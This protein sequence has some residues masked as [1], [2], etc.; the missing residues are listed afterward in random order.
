MKMGILGILA[1]AAAAFSQENYAQWS[2]YRDITINTSASGANVSG[3]VTNFPV[4]VRLTSGN[5]TDFATAGTKASLR[6]ARGSTPLKY[7]VDSFDSSGSLGAQ[8]WVSVDSVFG[9]NAA[10]SI[11]MYW[12]KSAAPDSSSGPKVFAPANKFAAVYHMGSIL[13]E[14]NNVTLSSSALNLKAPP[15]NPTDLAPAFVTGNIGQGLSFNGNGTIG[16]SSAM[17]VNS[18]KNDAAF[19]YVT[20]RTAHYTLS[21]WVKKGSSQAAALGMVI[22]KNYQYYLGF[23]NITN[24]WQMAEYTNTTGTD[25]VAVPAVATSDGWNYVV[26]VRNGASMTLYVNGGGG[27][28]TTF[29]GT[30]PGLNR[31]GGGTFNQTVGIGRDGGGS[32]AD[33]GVNPTSGSYFNGSIDELRVDSTSRSS[34]WVNL[35]YQTQNSAQTAVTV[36][37]AQNNVGPTITSL[38]PSDTT[39]GLGATATFNVAAT[40]TTPLIYQWMK[41]GVA[42]NTTANPS[43]ATASLVLASVAVGDTA[44]YTCVVS[45]SVNTSGVTS[46]A[47]NLHLNLAPTITTQ[48][49]DSTVVSGAGV[50]FTVAASGSGTLSYQWKKNGTNV[51]NGG[52]LSGATS[53]V[54]SVSA[55]AL[56][57]TGAYTVVVT[58]TLNGPTVSSTSGA[59]KLI[60]NAVS[61]ATQ[62]RD[63]TVLS[64]VAAGFTVAAS[65]TGVLSYQWKKNGANVS[66]GGTLSGATS[67]ALGVSSVAIT[68][69]G[70]Y[71]V[72]VT[73]TLNGTIATA[74]SNAGRLFVGIAPSI[75]TQPHDSTVVSGAAAGFTVAASGSGTLS[76]QW[77][78]NGTNV[79]NGGT[80]SG[81]TS[82]VLNV[83]AA[84]IT[85]TGAYTVAVTSTL[86]GTTTVATSS[87]G[88]LFV[89]IIPSITTQPHDST[90][91][92]G[93]AAGFT[94]AASGSGTL[95]YQWKKNGTNV[96]NAGT[97]S[98]ATSATLGISAVAITDTGSYTVTVTSTL[99]G[100]IAAVTSNAGKLKV[101]VAPVITTQ[102]ANQAAIVGTPAKFFVVAT[103]SLP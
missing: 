4:L 102:P 44:A 73:S 79:G 30:S 28:T 51:S 50:S 63:T 34:D 68:D 62:P 96:S 59:G 58:N 72:V 17:T 90:V 89:N 26:G 3:T 57:D 61:I 55:T 31:Q 52:T 19:N 13:A 85:D 45:N 101:V 6:F 20:D 53:A 77:K 14:L 29:S 36:G 86:N 64:G 38:T 75:T 16:A 100:T 7:Q 2:K 67:A 81:A 76:Y 35:S 70:S 24:N 103:G 42:V 15:S 95:S 56:T 84:A 88:R 94:V 1:C 83:S 37:A 18:S 11:R 65:G 87:A 99:N 47:G 41:N 46:A 32:I 91:V 97:L 49:H 93:A 12:G 43:A 22:C 69:T 66:N 78:K 48:P 8:V 10:Q 21:A 82:A 5:F 23:N 54:L 71:T 33:N 39:V 40:G 98:G 25:T 9:N 74:T 92:S 27:T 60:V 80:L